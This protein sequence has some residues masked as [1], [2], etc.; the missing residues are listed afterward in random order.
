MEKEF[1]QQCWEN[2]HIGWHQDDIHPWLADLLPS[3][4][5]AENCHMLVPLCGKSMDMLYL[6]QFGRVIPIPLSLCTTQS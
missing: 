4:S 2:D 3:I 1:W 6:A 5:Q